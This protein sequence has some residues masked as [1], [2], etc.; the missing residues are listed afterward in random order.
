MKTARTSRTVRA[1][2]LA[3]AA[4]FCLSLAAGSAQ[5]ATGDPI[6]D[7]SLTRPLLSGATR[8]AQGGNVSA[9]DVVRE[10]QA[11]RGSID[12]LREAQLSGPTALPTVQPEPQIVIANP[13]PGPGQT[14]NTT[15]TDRDP[16]NITGVGQM[17]VDTQDGFIGLCTGTL[18][19]PRTVIFAAHCVNE[20]DATLYGNKSG[21]RPIAFG[22]SN[23]N[24]TA[25]NSAFGHYLNTGNTNTADFLYNVNQVRYNPIS[26]TT[27][28]AGFL[29]GDIALASFD[30]PTKNI[31]TWAL[32]F[33]ALPARDLGAAGTG[34]HVVI[35]GYGN[36]GVASTGSVGGID[37][38]RRLAENMLGG[39]ASLDEFENFLFGGASTTNPQNVY[40]TDF[41]DPRRGTAGA[42]PYD[43]NAWR[44]NATPGTATKTSQEGTTAAGDSGGPLI[45]DNTYAKVVVIGVLSGGYTRFFGAQPANGYGTASFYQPLYL[46]WDWIAAN[47][48]YHYVGS[49]AGNGNWTDPTHWVTNI[50]PSYQVLTL[51]NG[52]LVLTNGVPTVAGAGNT[53]QPGFGEACFQSGGSSDC[54]NIATGQETYDPTG[55]PIGTN[56]DTP[57]G[58]SND[59]GNVASGSL[60]NGGAA[61]QAVGNVGDGS[62]SS[63]GSQ[64]S[65]GSQ[66][67]NALPPATLANGLPGATNFVPNNVDPVRLT[68]AIGKYFDVSLVAAGTTTLDTAVTIDR[69]SIGIGGGNA[70]LDVKSTGSLTSLIDITQATG[71]IHANGLISTPGDYMMVSGG[72]DGT[73]TVTAAFFTSVAGTIAPG[74]AGT[75]GTLNFRGNL[76]LASGST[77]NLDLGANGVSDKIAVAANGAG[78]GLANLGGRLVLGTSAATLRGGSTY[79]ILTSAG[80]ISGKF[81]DPAAFSAILSPK[82]TYTANAVTL[83]IAIRPYGTVVDATN[84]IQVSYALLLDRNR[85]NAANYDALYGPLDLQ[86]QATIRSTLSALAPTTET[87]GQS[88]GIAGVDNW[89]GVVR[90]R[91]D[92][93][94]PGDTGGTLARY[95]APAQVASN[96]ISA[97][98]MGGMSAMGFGADVR[99]DTQEPLI[100]E[101]VLPDSVNGFLAGGYLTGD[102]TAMT[103][104]ANRDT[105]TGWYAAGG[106]ETSND[107]S[108]I[109]FAFS[110]TRLDGTGALAGQ[111]AHANLF[112]G[113]LYGKLDLGGA[114][115]DA[116]VTAGLLDLD[117]KRQVNFVGTPYTVTSNSGNLVAVT[118]V[119]LSK[120]FDLGAVRVTPRA[121]GRASHIDFSRTAETGGPM[122]LM[123]DHGP[124]N[125]VEA[126]GGLTIAGTGSVK[127]FLNGT[128]VHDFM[129]RPAVIGANFVGGVGGN[130]LFALNGQDKDWAEVSGGLTYESGNISIS[131]SAETT[132]ERQDVS[133]QA[134][135]G[136]ISL[137]F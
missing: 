23:S 65:S 8:E 63:D 32:L 39:L 33:S 58:L 38:R 35:E 3:S 59:R 110:Y 61:S 52:N 30:T 20:E 18:I 73:G 136:S 37:Y 71:T 17:I 54:L 79:T 7:G 2:L 56:A 14:G 119:G 103:G 109:G 87:M 117:T 28:C 116:M 46:Y 68:G 10:A 45:L 95:G 78:T 80:G 120:D 111:S 15:V 82:L 48:P 11:D 55:H 132:I 122:A 50:D 137:K 34:Y 112:Q 129:N 76:I 72:L 70:V 42:S 75:T 49:V 62:S 114:T 83:Q 9:G 108:S 84:P 94:H 96:G 43:F 124:V 123:I 128:L 106:L 81:I 29:C 92:S 19:N 118:E 93:M 134:Y 85:P 53:D 74:T 101:G 115:L 41:D 60:S 26:T 131:A 4:G 47:N 64:S 67:P 24:N 127:P 98:N 5:A 1:A 130:V 121:A 13:P 27:D 135:R 36:N 25:G 31:P 88:L 100:Q 40:W 91:I 97:M 44:D 126:R 90:N 57:G 125:S 113:S 6:T 89:S 16:V 21:G 86:D 12:A 22:F 51:V 69:F 99:S 107:T 66:S 105:Y 133:S 104:I 77:Y 102:S